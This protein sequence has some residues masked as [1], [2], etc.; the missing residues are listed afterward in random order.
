MNNASNLSVVT[1]AALTPEEQNDNSVQ[2]ARLDKH[3]ALWNNCRYQLSGA[4]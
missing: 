2:Y 3:W 1:T 4:Q